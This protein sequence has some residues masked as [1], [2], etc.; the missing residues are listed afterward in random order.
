MAPAP[1]EAVQK[2]GPSPM[3]WTTPPLPTKVV[4][5]WQVLSI[6]SGLN[7]HRS[8]LILS[9]LSYAKYASSIDNVIPYPGE[10]IDQLAKNHIYL[11]NFI[12]LTFI[13]C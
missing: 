11:T 7:N 1:G 12:F 8:P 10:T 6:S 5:Q 13:C 4:L 9:R 2:V 3:R